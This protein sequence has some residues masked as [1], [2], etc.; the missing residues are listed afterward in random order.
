V[1]VTSNLH[2]KAPCPVAT[3]CSQGQ[4][5]VLPFALLNYNR[6]KVSKKKSNNSKAV[7]KSAFA[8]HVGS[9]GHRTT[10]QDTFSQWPP[11]HR[12]WL[13]GPYHVNSQYVKTPKAISMQKTQVSSVFH[14]F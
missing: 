14:G 10:V 2:K 6:K 13:Q 8:G 9:Q 7:L 1:G 3:H 12:N 5:E 4:G 11:M